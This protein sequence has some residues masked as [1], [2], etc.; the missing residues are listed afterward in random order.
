[1]VL[2]AA[3]KRVV[4]SME[5]MFIPILRETAVVTAIKTAIRSM[6]EALVMVGW[7]KPPSIPP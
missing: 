7:P 1:M 5:E 6:Q 3:L 4:G 2:V